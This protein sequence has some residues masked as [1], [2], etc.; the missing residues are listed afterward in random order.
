M[1]DF[2]DDTTMSVHLRENNYPYA[3]KGTPGK[4][5]F[6][7]IHNNKLDQETREA[8]LRSLVKSRRE[9]RSAL[10]VLQDTRDSLDRDCTGTARDIAGLLKDIRL[11]RP[12]Y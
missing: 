9:N 2:F 4:W 10:E 8:K 11:L 12:R 7:R 1:M 6:V 5:K 3:K